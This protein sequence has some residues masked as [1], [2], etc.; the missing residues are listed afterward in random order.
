MILQFCYQE[1][2]FKGAISI[3]FIYVMYKYNMTAVVKWKLT[4]K[5][6]TVNPVCP[7]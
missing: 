6:K 5:P 4:V 3:T 2:N 7:V 1:N